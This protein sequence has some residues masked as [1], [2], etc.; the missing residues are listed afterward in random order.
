M[1]TLT[2][3][4]L[5]EAARKLDLLTPA[6]FSGVTVTVSLHATERVLRW[7]DKK[8]S[9]RLIKKMTKK[10]GPQVWMKPA[11][12]NTPMGLV[13]HPEIYGRLRNMTGRT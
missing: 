4:V 2:M 9:R 11:A 13:V 10:R 8:R 12:F 3:D 1:T 7:P 5:R 6:R